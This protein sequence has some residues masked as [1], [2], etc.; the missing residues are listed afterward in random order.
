MALELQSES[1]DYRTEL[2]SPLREEGDSAAA[3][4][5]A[6]PS[7]RLNVNDFAIQEAAKK[8]P[9]L[10]SRVLRRFHGNSSPLSFDDILQRLR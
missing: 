5:A 7:W 3:M 8:D 2:L 10:A 9:P 1:M 4:V 6:T